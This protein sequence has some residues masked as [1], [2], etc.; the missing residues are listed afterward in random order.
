MDHD[1]MWLR[2]NYN[3]SVACSLSNFA[4]IQFYVTDGIHAIVLD[5]EAAENL[6]NFILTKLDD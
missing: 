6:A 1:R 3:A 5:K 2:K 4:S